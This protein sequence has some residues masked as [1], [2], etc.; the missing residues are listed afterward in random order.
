MTNSFFH[1]FSLIELNCAACR[2]RALCE[3]ETE[4]SR[5]RKRTQADTKAIS[6][7]KKK[8]ED[9][10]YVFVPVTESNVPWLYACGVQESLSIQDCPQVGTLQ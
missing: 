5:R 8:N 4:L 2:L 1:L 6:S 10:S 9:K 7:F 3:G